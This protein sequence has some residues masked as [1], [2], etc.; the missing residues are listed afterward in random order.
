MRKIRSRKN[1]TCVTN[2]AFGL[3][4]NRLAAKWLAR[5]RGT[6][7]EYTKRTDEGHKKR[8]KMSTERDKIELGVHATTL[9]RTQKG[10]KIRM[11]CA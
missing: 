3:Q 7:N 6:A 9:N 5:Y 4:T 11:L 10:Q 1:V 2:T 8:R